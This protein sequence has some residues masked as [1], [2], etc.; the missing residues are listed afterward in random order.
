[1]LTA[2]IP[3]DIKI[4]MSNALIGTV[5]TSEHVGAFLEEVEEL[6]RKWGISQ[7]YVITRMLEEN[8]MVSYSVGPLGFDSE[9]YAAAAQMAAF[10]LGREKAVVAANLSE[11]SADAA[12]AVADEFRE[13]A[14]NESK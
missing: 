10:A 8:N 1:M 12:Q 6:R 14:G 4:S 11:L 3:S 7:A 5:E 2:C 13:Q 9:T